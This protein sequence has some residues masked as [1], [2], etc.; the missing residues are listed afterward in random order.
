MDL[1]LDLTL[2]CDYRLKFRNYL[3]FVL[4]FNSILII[5]LVVSTRVTYTANI[6]VTS[7]IC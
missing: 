4:I 3:H 1:G 5:R 7:L 2:K 6:E